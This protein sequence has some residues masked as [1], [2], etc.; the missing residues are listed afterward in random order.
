MAS[1]NS[2]DIMAQVDFVEIKNAI[3]QANKEISKRYDFKG[4]ITNIELVQKD[5]KIIIH[6]EDDYKLTSVR[7]VLLTKMA[8]RKVPVKA[9]QFGKKQDATGQT[10]R[11]EV[12]IQEGIPQEKAKEIVKFIKSLG[13]KKVQAS[14]QKDV[15]RVSGKDKDELQ[16]VIT[17]V[18][19]QDFGI[20]TDFGNYR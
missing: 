17:Q 4:S 8:S 19:A 1:D 18:K 9:F 2:F 5:H 20:F 3:E 13:F 6:T 10:I 11:Q 16:E 12:E 14:I 7:E 15:I